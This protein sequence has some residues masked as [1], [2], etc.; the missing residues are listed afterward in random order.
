MTVLVVTL[1]L[2]AGLAVWAAG[3]A[4]GASE[5]FAAGHRAGPWL[6]GLAGTA[7]AVSGFTFVGGPGLFAVAGAGSLWLILS[8]P[9]TGAL[10]CWVVGERV[11]EDRPDRP[12]TVPELL[13]RRLGGRSVGAVAAIAVLVG[14][15]ASLAVQARA[16]AVLGETFLG[17]DGWLTAALVMAAVTAYTAAGGMRAGL[18]ADA[19]QGAVMALVAVGLAGAAL[20]AAGGPLAAVDYLRASRPELLGAFGSF[21]PGRA[22]SLYL[23]FALGTLAQPHYVQKFLF[24]RR[25]ADLRLLPAVLTGALTAM[26]A[27]WLGVG[28]AGAALQAEGRITVVRPDELAPRVMAL[29]GPWAVLLAGVAVLAAMMSTAASFLNLAAA[30]VT[31]DLP[32]AAGRAPAGVGAARWA[33]VA[34]ALAATVLGV[35]SDRAVAWLGIAGWG[36]FTAALLPVMALGLAW[37]GCRPGPAAAAV[38]VGALVDVGLELSRAHLP[39]AVEPGLAGAAVGTLVLVLGSLRWRPAGEPTGSTA[40]RAQPPV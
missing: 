14:C 31:R 13:A 12:I 27:V 9:F 6:A 29:L 38:A 23:L 18:L 4:R 20:F 26:L 28:L 5:F 33:T 22:A 7:A 3:K 19:V 35:A 39:A 17:L 36:F 16:A 1:L 8:A 25:R 21:E 11:V 15:V 30:A 37:R 32:A 10:Q 34:T 24:V 40:H 2:A